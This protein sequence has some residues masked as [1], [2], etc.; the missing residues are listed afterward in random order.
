[1]FEMIGDEWLISELNTETLEGLV[2]DVHN[3]QSAVNKMRKTI[4]DLET[5]IQSSNI[6][7]QDNGSLSRSTTESSSCLC[8]SL[9]QE[10][11]EAIEKKFD[12]LKFVMKGNVD[13]ESLAKK[14]T[15]QLMDFSKSENK[16]LLNEIK[17][18]NQSVKKDILDKVKIQNNALKQEVT[19]TT[20]LVETRMNQNLANKCGSLA[21]DMTSLRN[22]VN[23]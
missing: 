7:A 3:V 1:M 22:L 17:E 19:S 4:N 23:E 16:D 8:Q 9:K 20:K 12:D 18:S 13:D 11:M 15:T 2:H 14:I 10:I 6:G 21:K 5:T